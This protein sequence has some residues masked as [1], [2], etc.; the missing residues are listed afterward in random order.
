[1]SSPPLKENKVTELFGHAARIS[2]R[3]DWRV[4]ASEQHCPYLDRKCIKTRKSQPEIAIGTCTVRY[5]R[6][7]DESVV[8]CPHRLLERRQVFTDCL[9]L[10]TLH[11]P[12]NE[13]HVVGEV[14]IPGGSVDYFLVSADNRKVVDFVG[15]E[16]QTLDTSG[17]A[18]PDRQRFLASAGLTI[19]K[20][21]V[22]SPKSFGMNWKMTAKTILVKLHHK[23]KTFEH[24][25]RRLV[26]VVQDRL[27][28][29]MR[30]E[31]SFEH[32]A[33][34]PRLGDSMHVHAYGLE[35][36]GAHFRLIL[37]G[38]VSTDTEGIAT[39]LGLQA[40]PN[41]ELVHIVKILERKISGETLVTI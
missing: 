13:L 7:E 21:D 4:I 27:L 35:R 40:S 29:Y 3:V 26:L 34:P 15:I 14:R 5:G 1:M 30:G 25:N 8:I 12:G 37:R 22:D 32:L 38:R 17:T 19:P 18:W 11:E 9:H 41:I 36:H 16:F 10:L 23:I 24:I 6:K 20:S 31:F 33:D 2:A 28:E 39:C